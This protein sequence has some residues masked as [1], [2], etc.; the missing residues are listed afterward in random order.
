MALS[1]TE[2]A[3]WIAGDKQFVAGEITFDSSYPTGGEA[4]ASSISPHLEQVTS[5]LAFPS[6]AEVPV[7]DNA[8]DKLLLYTADGTEATNT[9]DQ[10]GVSVFALLIGT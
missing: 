8:N 9:S 1:F 4:V 7:W 10:S 3:Q 6:G 2:H 5:V